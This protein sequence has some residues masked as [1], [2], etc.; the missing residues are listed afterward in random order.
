MK[1]WNALWLLNFLLLAGWIKRCKSGEG[2]DNYDEFFW[3]GIHFT[4]VHTRRL[5]TESIIFK[6]EPVHFLCLIIKAQKCRRNE[7]LLK[8]TA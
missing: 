2:N 4:N 7:F 1:C 3:I 5:I 8:Q 6:R